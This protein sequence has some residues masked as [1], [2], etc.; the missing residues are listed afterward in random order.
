MIKIDPLNTER[1]VYCLWKGEFNKDLRK[2]MLIIFD[3]NWEIQLNFV[4]LSTIFEEA[5]EGKLKLEHKDID[6][7]H[8][9]IE[10]TFNPCWS[11]YV[12][13]VTS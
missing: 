12:N 13:W 9:Y 4:E 11:I 1:L 7:F 5:C 8:E 3:K 2:V 10:N 6:T